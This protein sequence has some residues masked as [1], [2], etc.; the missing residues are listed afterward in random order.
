MGLEPV[1]SPIIPPQNHTAIHLQILSQTS[2]PKSHSLW[3]RG[4]RTPHQIKGIVPEWEEPKTWSKANFAILRRKGNFL[5][6]SG[7]LSQKVSWL[8][9]KER[10]AAGCHYSSEFN[11][12]ILKGRQ[13]RLDCF[14]A[15][16]PKWKYHSGI[17]RKCWAEGMPGKQH[18]TV[19]CGEWRALG[20]S[21]HPP[22]STSIFGGVTRAPPSLPSGDH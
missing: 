7:N 10:V 1:Q 8:L 22:W 14:F 3:K 2:H 19:S 4:G 5:Q 16:K 9:R 21:A 6:A 15:N 18:P 11:V 20:V 12:I 13:L 17:M